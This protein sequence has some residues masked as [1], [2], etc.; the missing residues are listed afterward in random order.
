MELES[1]AMP[2]VDAQIVGVFDGTESIA[3]AHGPEYGD[4]DMQDGITGACINEAPTTVQP[5]MLGIEAAPPLS[6]AVQFE[7]MSEAFEQ[8]AAASEPELSEEH[9]V[10]GEACRG[11]PVTVTD[12]ELERRLL[13]VVIGDMGEPGISGEVMRGLL[14][15]NSL[16]ERIV[17]LVHTFFDHRK[18]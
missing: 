2:A 9:G 3:A 16:L 7:P 18:K 10:D 1:S 15:R 6:G 8:P 5:S 11:Q 17:D 12:E 14:A 13:R 4:V